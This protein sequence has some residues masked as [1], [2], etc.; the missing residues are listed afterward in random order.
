MGDLG[1]CRVLNST[2]SKAKTAVGTPYYMSPEVISGQKYCRKA[3]IWSLGILLYYMCTLQLP[4]SG[5]SL[6]KIATKIKKGVYEPIPEHYS[7]N[8]SNLISSMLN[9][10]HSQRPSI[11]QVLKFP[12][13]WAKVGALLLDEKYKEQ[14]SHATINGINTFSQ[15]ENGVKDDVIEDLKQR[16]LTDTYVP[17]SG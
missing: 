6:A 12:K 17:K 16:F 13:V 5:N 14:F 1:I 3:D 11:N 7:P 10:D 15:N 4:F 2:K 8:L 9:T